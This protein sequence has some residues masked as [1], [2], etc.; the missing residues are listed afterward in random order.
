MTE[1]ADVVYW[2][3]LTLGICYSLEAIARLTLTHHKRSTRWC[4]SASTYALMKLG[5]AGGLLIDRRL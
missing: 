2:Q 5:Q 4:T 1:V 3:Q